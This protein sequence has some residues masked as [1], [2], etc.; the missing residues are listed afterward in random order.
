MKFFTGPDPGEGDLDVALED[1]RLVQKWKSERK[2][3]LLSI[4]IKPNKMEQLQKQPVNLID[5]KAQ[6]EVAQPSLK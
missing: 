5:H 4:P 3:L 1:E 2:R 6:W